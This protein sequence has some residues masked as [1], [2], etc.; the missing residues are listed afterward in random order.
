MNS[1][2]W[3]DLAAIQIGWLMNTLNV[4]LEILTS[5]LKLMPRDYCMHDGRSSTG[6]PKIGSK[7]HLRNPFSS[8]R[9]SLFKWH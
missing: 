3:K 9:Y 4:W 6:D 2:I 5:S 1:R 8:L 7:L